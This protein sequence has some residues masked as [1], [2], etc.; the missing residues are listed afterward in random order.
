MKKSGF[1]VFFVLLLFTSVNLTAGFWVKQLNAGNQQILYEARSGM[2]LSL[3]PEYTIFDI[4]GTIYRQGVFKRGNGEWIELQETIS[5]PDNSFFSLAYSYDEYGEKIGYYKIIRFSWFGDVLFVKG[6]RVNTRLFQL[7]KFLRVGDKIKLLGYEDPGNLIGNV[8]V[9]NFTENG[10]LLDF[11]RFCLNIKSGRFYSSNAAFIRTDADHYLIIKTGEIRVGNDLFK[12]I[13]LMKFTV[14]DDLTMIKSYYNPDILGGHFES[15]VIQKDP[16]SGYMLL[17]V[18][19][20]ND[21]GKITHTP[22]LLKFDEN[23]QLKWNR[24]YRTDTPLVLLKDTH[25]LPGQEGYIIGLNKS[26]TVNEEPAARPLLIRTDRDGV[27]SW[28]KK[29][30]YGGTRGICDILKL[31]NGGLLM[32]AHDRYFYL[33]N[34]SGDV[35][36]SCSSIN[37]ISFTCGT[38]EFIEKPITNDRVT[39]SLIPTGTTDYNG[40]FDEYEIVG[41]DGAET[42][43][44]FPVLQGE[45]DTVLERSRFS[46]YLIHRVRF[47]VDPAIAPYIS[48]IHVFRKLS[49]PTADYEFVSEVVKVEGQADYEIEY[50]PFLLGKSFYNYKIIA[51]NQDGELIDY[52][53][54]K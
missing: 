10:E 26:I 45:F 33:L 30:E 40:F 48:K 36:G 12:G 9:L 50:R 53:F 54:L 38:T 41:N 44:H 15:P 1:F 7:G 13:H 52:A 21:D 24:D 43:C 6:V 31:N 46:G 28:S 49:D 47:S 39:T 51:Y 29:Y 8:V 16:E 32:S 23:W 4:K 37:Q 20:T 11:R 35:P 34:G 14:D 17:L 27:L 3:K 5:L 42:I 25:L 2:F 22:R 19:R 18:E